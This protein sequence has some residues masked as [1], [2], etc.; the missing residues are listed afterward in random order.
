[1]TVEPSQEDFAKALLDAGHALPPGLRTWDGSDPAQRF[2]VYRNNVMTS[3]TQ[4][5]ASGFAVTRELVGARFF[6][7]MAR[8]YVMSEPPTS[9]VL[10]EY[11]NGF[12]DFIS[13]FPPAAGL[14]YLPDVARLERM[15][16]QSHHAPDASLLSPQVLQ[17]MMSDPEALANLRVRLHPACHILRS[18]F[19]VFSIWA[20]HH[21]YDESDRGAALARVATDQAEDALVRRPLHEVSV[22]SLPPGVADFLLALANGGSLLDAAAAAAATGGFQLET[23]MAIVITPGVARR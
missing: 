7:A 2:A 20:A 17:E 18:R 19:A 4:A 21:Q 15:R 13:Q 22:M 9:P 1:M 14:P 16:V 23:G 8:E 11:G 5:L 12:A 10:V 6:D 3:L